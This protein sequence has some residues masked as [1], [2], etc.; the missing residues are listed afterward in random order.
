MT[1]PISINELVLLTGSTASSDLLGY[2]LESNTELLANLIDISQFAKHD[3]TDERTKTYEQYLY[4]SQQPI[5]S[6]VGVKEIDDDEI[7]VDLT[8][9]S[10]HAILVQKNGDDY[11]IDDDLVKISYNA[12][13]QIEEIISVDINPSNDDT[14][15]ITDAGTA[16]TW[17]FK[18]SGPTGNQILIGANTDATA[19][20]IATALSGSSVASIV[21]LP[22]GSKITATADI[23]VNTSAFFPADLKMALSMMVN[24]S[25][26]DKTSS[27]GAKVKSYSIGSKSVQY[28]NTSE[29]GVK[30]ESIFENLVKKYISR[31]R[32][33]F[34]SGV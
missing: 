2:L 21:T 32:R 20:N 1:S 8:I 19:T 3:I 12:G 30:D 11:V 33:S 5:N 14:L 15:V 17:T 24:S 16:T 28:M 31:F 10:G 25:L 34:I 4:P 22:V 23:T 18:S 9:E 13:W 27:S 29:Q 26:G 7:D 6:V